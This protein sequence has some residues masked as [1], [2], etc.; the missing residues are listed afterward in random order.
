MAAQV[1]QLR[2][3]PLVE[4]GMAT[5][6]PPTVRHFQVFLD[7]REFKEKM[8]ALL[9]AADL[10]NNGPWKVNGV[11]G[12][13]RTTRIPE[14]SGFRPDDYGVIIRYF[15]AD[16]HQGGLFRL[17]T[18]KERRDEVTQMLRRGASLLS[19]EAVDGSTEATAEA[20][21]L[22]R[23]ESVFRTV[24]KL[25]T[26]SRPADYADE[27][28]FVNA[29]A[30]VTHLPAGG[31]RLLL[32]QL[33]LDGRLYRRDPV[34]VT[35]EMAEAALA[36]PAGPPP[37]DPFEKVVRD[38]AE[39]AAQLQTIAAAGPA[40]KARQAELLELQRQRDELDGKIAAA[41][42][43]L[44]DTRAALR[45]ALAG[46]SST[47]LLDLATEID[48]AAAIGTRPGESG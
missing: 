14:W 17:V 45:Q 31:V 3:R 10:A 7:S 47:R 12:F 30:S 39:A 44:T 26:Y 28:M 35:K 29:A 43:L 19:G 18:P 8:E 20:L 38:A 9:R 13:V 4:F 1:P 37:E 23:L 25:Y 27:A 24:A 41:A 21:E 34:W 2:T 42:A 11:Q 46:V 32:K 36:K 40:I 48:T 16:I 33:E 15:D 5:A 6:N 22:E